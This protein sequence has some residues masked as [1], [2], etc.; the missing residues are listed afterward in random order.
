MSVSFIL[1]LVKDYLFIVLLAFVYLYIRLVYISGIEHID[2]FLF[3]LIGAAVDGTKIALIFLVTIRLIKSEFVFLII[4]IVATGTNL[5]F[6]IQRANQ[7]GLTKRINDIVYYDHGEV[8]FFGLIHE[9]IN[10]PIFLS[11][12]L[13]LFLYLKTLKI[14]E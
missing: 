8:S 5:F 10:D 2:K 12:P 3:P 1:T 14:K 13:A 9:T 6:S 7:I 4:S 11:V